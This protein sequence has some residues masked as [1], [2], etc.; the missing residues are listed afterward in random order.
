[1]GP[2]P[3]GYACSS[4]RRWHFLYFFLPTPRG[5]PARLALPRGKRAWS[6]GRGGCESRRALGGEG[7]RLGV[8][9]ELCDEPASGGIGLRTLVLLRRG[10]L[11]PHLRSR[12]AQLNKDMISQQVVAA[13][14]GRVSKVW[15]NTSRAGIAVVDQIIRPEL[16]VR[17]SVSSEAA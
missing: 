5:V 11:P 7:W 9:G 10:Q 2:P 1:M 8:P 14:I 3:P 12:A 4:T 17:W 15:A 16:G 13:R 6:R